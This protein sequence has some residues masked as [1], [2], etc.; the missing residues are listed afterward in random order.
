[1]NA[2]DIPL[3]LIP[4]TFFAMLAAESIFGTS[5]PWRRIPW[6]RMQGFLRHGRRRQRAAAPARAARHCEASPARCFDARA[7]RQYRGGLSRTVVDHGRGASRVSP[8]SAAMAHVSP[9][10]S[11]AAAARHGGRRGVHAAGD[12]R[13]RD[14]DAPRARLRSG[15]EPG[16]GFDHGLHS[17]V[18]QFLPALQRAHATLA[19][20]ADPAA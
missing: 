20:C 8:I 9:A 18:L 6:W 1:M 15:L 5:R 3:L 19:R 13:Q 11:C 4:V 12:N 10:P 16:G 17:R 7:R 2:E 14:I